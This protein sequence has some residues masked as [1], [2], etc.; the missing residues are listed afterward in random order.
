MRLRSPHDPNPHDLS[1]RDPRPRAGWQLRR[2]RRPRGLAAACA[3][4]LTTAAM[5]A[6]GSATGAADASPP[7][8]CTTSDL[9]VTI[10]I[11]AA[12]T[13]AGSTYYPIDFTNA[14]AARCSM[15][16]YPDTWFGTSTGKRIG[17]P[18]T[19]N[20]SVRAR[21]VPLAPG[22]SAH[23]W[24]QVTDAANYP[25]KACH[26]VTANMLLVRAPGATQASQVWR[27]FP[28]CAAAMHGHGI[29]SV[30][31]VL[32]GRGRRGSA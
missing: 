10:D 7:G 16:G 29:L 21:P 1:P 18:A 24:L 9:I 30:Q 6:C 12:G 25:A 31:P 17:D 27:A 15:D 23:A 4:A 2:P 26:P 13:A 28:T 32:P 5:A 11:K 20:R 22:A 14:S 19:R 8:A 3:A